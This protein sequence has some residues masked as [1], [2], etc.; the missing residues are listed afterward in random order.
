MNNGEGGTFAYGETKDER[1]RTMDEGRK[2]AIDFVVPMVFP[3]DPQWQQ[4]YARY[5]GSATSAQ[6]N[7]RWRSWGTERLMVECVMR[8]MPWVRHIHLLL[9]GESQEQPWMVEL[10]MKSEKL[11]IHFHQEFIPAKYLPCF[12]SP[13]IEMFLHRIPG[14]AEHFIYANDDMFPLSPLEREDFFR[15]PCS[16]TAMNGG[17]PQS[18]TLRNGGKGGLL[19]CQQWREEPF[20]VKPNVFQR[21]CIEQLNMVG[22]YYGKHFRRTWLK[23]GHSFMPLLKSSCVE[24][25]QRHWAEIVKYLSPLKRTEHS[26]NHY[27][28]ALY[29]HFE[30]KEVD[31]AP[32]EQ[33]VERK[34]PTGTIAEII[35]DKNAGIV[36]FNDNELIDD[37]ARRAEIVREEIEKRLL[38]S[39]RAA[40]EPILTEKRKTK[41]GRDGQPGTAEESILITKTITKDG[42]DN[43]NEK[44]RT[45]MDVLIIHYNT[46]ELTVAAVR[47]LWKNTPHAK[48]TIFDNSDKRP[49]CFD[50]LDGVNGSDGMIEI[51]DNTRGQCVDLDAWLQ[52]FPK[53]DPTNDNRYASARHCKSVDWC[54]K[55]FPD[56]FL[57]MDSDVLVRQD[58]T[59]LFDERFAW[60]GQKK[61]HRSK[62][63]VKIRR[64]LP[65][66]CYINTRMC[67]EYGI[68][69]CN[70]EKMYGLSMRQPDTSYDTGCWFYEAVSNANLPVHEVSIDDYILHLGHGSWQE[71]GADAW[72]HQHRAL[73]KEQKDNVRIYVCTH[74]DFKQV[75]HNKAYEVVD[76]RQY[77]GD[78]CENGLHG[79]FYSELITYKHIAARNDLPEYVGFCGYRKY[80]S[81]MDNI[82]DMDE[83]FRNYDAVAATPMVVKPDVRG[84]YAHCHNV[85]DLDI[86]IDIVRKDYPNLFSAFMDALSQPLLYACNMFIVKRVDFLWMIK[87]VFDILDQYIAVVGTGIEDRIRAYPEDYHLGRPKT[88]TVGYQYR[89]GGFLGER[90]VNALLRY[91]FERIKHYDKVVTQ[92]SLPQNGL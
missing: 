80:F 19:P 72:L 38:Q 33:Y 24:V 56:G 59:P 9:S 54:M 44:R 53:K 90:I 34:T 41:D 58:V 64:V 70:P 26:Y 27:I 36:C 7:V 87:V 16:E 45:R 17:E 12:T 15:E 52:T 68:D 1:R 22:G 23:S 3:A 55:M 32:R 10:K 4:E 11:K 86:A 29:Q 69:Y 14:L 78:M 79:S 57:L 81:F 42:N 25:H 91:R 74:T 66:L 6:K 67:A 35:R 30:G 39:E 37:W 76:A 46:P 84:Q 21:K 77:N 18:E 31:Y 60:V 75:V 8:F 85:K 2:K 82:P 62:Y 73:W 20:P 49:F 65:F 50:G 13:T 40:A 71:V 92:K 5:R 43:D 48:V 63:G 51:I 88:G 47:S 89:I 28:Y 83:V 61:S